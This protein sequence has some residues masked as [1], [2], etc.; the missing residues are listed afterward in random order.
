MTR[1]CTLV[2][3]GDKVDIESMFRHVKDFPSAGI[4]FIDVT[5][6]LQ[7]PCAFAYIVD[8]F[9]SQLRDIDFDLI[10][11]VESRGFILGAA[12]AYALKKGLVP[13]RKRGKLPYETIFEKYALEYGED[14]LEM[15][16]DAVSK[17]QKVVLV[18]D[19]LATG[20]TVSASVRLIER[21]GGHVSKVLFLAELSDLALSDI[22]NDYSVFSLVKL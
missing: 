9:A 21:L 20:G 13:I 15:H 19:I 22:R 10:A 16:I 4:D 3:G 8:C 17:G 7:D 6:V 11:C 5:P 18:D 14:V 2:L 12:L 1:Q